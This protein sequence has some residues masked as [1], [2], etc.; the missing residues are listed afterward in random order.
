MSFEIDI[1]LASRAG[2]HGENEDFAAAR[3]LAGG[4]LA[5]LADGGGAGS[6][7]LAAQTTVL[8]LLQ[9]LP[10]VPPAWPP[11]VALDRLLQAQNA[12]L[13]AQNRRAVGRGEGP[14]LSTL[15]ALLLQG[16]RYVLCHVGDSRA[17][18]LRDGHCQLLTLDHRLPRADFAGLTRAVGLDDGL[19]LEHRRGELRPGDRLLLTSD[20]VH[21]YLGPRELAR[22]LAAAADATQAAEALVSAACAAGRSDDA[23]ALVIAVGGP[24]PP[25]AAA[26]PASA[27]GLPAPPPLAPGEWLD[28]YRVTALLDGDG[29]LRCA[30]ALAPGQGRPVLLKRPNPAA[31]ERLGHELW[32]V[33]HLAES[34]RRRRGAGRRYDAALLRVLPPRAPSAC[35]GVFEWPG[36][37]SLEQRL[38]RGP[39]P[40]AEVQALALAVSGVLSLLHAAGGVLRELRP[41]ALWRDEQG[42][43][44]LLDLSLALSPRAPAALR[45][46]AVAPAFAGPRAW[47]DP[48]RPPDM[49]ADLFALG[50]LLYLALTGRPPYDEASATGRGRPLREPP[51]LARL[52]PQT[53]AALAR[54]VERL[55]TRGRQGRFES[56]DELR[57]ALER[58]AADDQA[59]PRGLARLGAER[60]RPWQWGLA[61]SLLAN[62]LLLA[63]LLGP[64]AR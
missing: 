3:P 41:A 37:E 16:E 19:R 62:L 22:V 27:A 14:G 23:S 25:G 20:G 12:W 8:S 60:L 18:L 5:V 7:R 4:W 34:A 29:P 28:G 2:P 58:G 11:H 38:A 26:P 47:R 35:Y 10:A 32:L 17:W 51:P 13:L 39:L 9:D 64:P 61:L 44:R 15:T 57:L 55:V 40:A 52:A 33:E 46:L 54:T 1:G 31:R 30:Q 24:R 21:D 56:A 42:G 49:A 45:G 50:A 59:R 36:G 6:G 48:A 53:P 43:W 63:W